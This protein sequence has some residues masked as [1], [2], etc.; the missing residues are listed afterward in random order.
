M[1]FSF[2]EKNSKLFR[3]ATFS[4]IARIIRNRA[5]FPVPTVPSFTD[6]EIKKSYADYFRQLKLLEKSKAKYL[7]LLDFER[8]GD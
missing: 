2:G 7:R 1:R 3:L 8:I 4:G 6:Q 5:F